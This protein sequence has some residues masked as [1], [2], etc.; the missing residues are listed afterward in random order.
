M[1]SKVSQMLG[2]ASVTQKLFEIEIYYESS[3]FKFICNDHLKFL[4]WYPSSSSPL[5]S[6]KL[7][8]VYWKTPTK[9]SAKFFP[10]KDWYEFSTHVSKQ[11]TEL[12]TKDY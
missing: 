5:F 1:V 10:W 4:I 11:N 9:S 7:E 2:G 8:Y 3:S 6:A 12:T